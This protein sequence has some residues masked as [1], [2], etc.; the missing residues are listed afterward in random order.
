MFS[1][2]AQRMAPGHNC[3]AHNGQ[4]CLWLP[5][6]RARQLVLLLAS[7]AILMQG[8]I[9]PHLLIG[10]GMQPKLASCP[11]KATIPHINGDHIPRHSPQQER[12]ENKIQTKKKTKKL[13]L[14]VLKRILAKAFP[15][16]WQS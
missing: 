3:T 12:R 6:S 7:K 14:N 8:G 16:L 13:K 15:Q 2:L 4:V 11:L 9:A 5:S 10:M 1:A